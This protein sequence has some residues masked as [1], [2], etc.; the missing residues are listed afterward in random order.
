MLVFTVACLATV[1][2]SAFD[3]GGQYAAHGVV[4]CAAHLAPQNREPDGSVAYGEQRWLEG[5]IHAFNWL[6]P[7]TFQILG[8]SDVRAALRW[9]DDFCANNRLKD[10][11]EGV[12]ALFGEPYPKRRRGKNISGEK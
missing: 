10:T 2:A 3:D 4:T 12:E 6:V 11:A 1:P 8:E 5:V 7:D 9:L